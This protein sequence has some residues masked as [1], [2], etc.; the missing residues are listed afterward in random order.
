MADSINSAQIIIGLFF[1]CY[2]HKAI[3]RTRQIKT[4]LARSSSKATA[5][6]SLNVFIGH[7][8]SKKTSYKAL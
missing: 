8:I 2:L 7:K 6:E 4:V 5:I 3:N 1:V